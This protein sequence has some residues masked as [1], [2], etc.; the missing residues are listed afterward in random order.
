MLIDHRYM[1][2]CRVTVI[3]LI[4]IH[5]VIMVGI[6]RDITIDIIHHVIDM[7]TGTRTDNT[8]VAM[9]ETGIFQ[10]SV[11]HLKEDNVT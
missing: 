6:I 11:W 7:M 8:T 3:D 9:K 4:I 2:M 10:T 1:Y 5:R